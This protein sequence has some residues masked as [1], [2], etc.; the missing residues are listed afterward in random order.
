MS[1]IRGAIGILKEEEIDLS[2]PINILCRQENPYGFLKYVEEDLKAI[3][4]ETNYVK[5]AR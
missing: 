2:R 5:S 3:G 4:I 1:I